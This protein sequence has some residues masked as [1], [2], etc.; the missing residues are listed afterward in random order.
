MEARGGI[1][2]AF[3]TGPEPSDVDPDTSHLSKAE[4]TKVLAERDETR[5][6][7]RLIENTT[8]NRVFCVTEKDYIGLVPYRARVNDL[9]VVLFGG[10]TPFVLR[11]RE[12]PGSAETGRRWQLIGECYVHGFMDGEA[13]DDG[14][15]EDGTSVN[16]EEF[17]LA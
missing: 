16:S 2:E 9:I 10:H 11:E 7:K 3:F 6:V 14:L 17:V 1:N 4:S 13:L 15:Y 12:V 8:M 5:R